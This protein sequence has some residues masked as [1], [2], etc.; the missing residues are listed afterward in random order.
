M[1]NKA[2]A[3]AL[4]FVFQISAVATYC[5][6]K[7]TRV[8]RPSAGHREGVCLQGVSFEILLFQMAIALNW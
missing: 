1:L 7:I 4:L 8:G 6:L 5:N 3:A 2:T